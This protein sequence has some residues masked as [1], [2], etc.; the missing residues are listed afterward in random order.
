MIARVRTLFRYSL[1]LLFVC[2]GEVAIAA[3]KKTKTLERIDGCVLIENR[4]NDG[5]TFRVKLPDGREETLR[6]Y[7]VDAPELITRV[8][9]RNDDARVYF[10]S[11]KERIVTLAKEADEFT[12]SA[13]SK[14]FTIYTRWR[15]VFSSPRYY[16]FIFTA[17]S[18]DLAELLVSRGLASIHGPRDRAPDGRQPPAYVAKLRE[19]EKR[20]KEQAL[21]GWKR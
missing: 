18:E 8:F 14:P 9:D 16:A 13:L 10:G 17:G 21:G 15:P 20:A 2:T 1:A 7:Y 12:R 6:L 4:W 19:L 5:D 11:D 3:P